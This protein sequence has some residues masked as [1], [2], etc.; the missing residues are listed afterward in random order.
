VHKRLSRAIVD[1][2]LPDVRLYVRT[3]ADADAREGQGMSALEF[4]IEHTQLD[5]IRYLL[6]VGA[7][8]NSRDAAGQTPLHF[9]ISSEYDNEISRG[10]RGRRV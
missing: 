1:G 2:N 10:H 7:N 6:A 5:I 9:A 8:P 4:A 3:G